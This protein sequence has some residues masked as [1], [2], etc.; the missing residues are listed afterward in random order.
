MDLPRSIR[1]SS[2]RLTTRFALS[3]FSICFALVVFEDAA[4]A[5]CLEPHPKVC[6]EFFRSDAVFVGTVLTEREVPPEGSSYDGWLY[7]IRIKQTFRGKL[8]SAVDV[9]TENSSGRYPL[10]VDETYLLF[11]QVFEGRLNIDNCGN[12]GPI[13]KTKDLI[14]QIHT[15]KRSTGGEIEGVVSVP[16]SVDDAS[17]IVIT[18]RGGQKTY[19]GITAKDGS[20]RIRVP[21]GEYKVEAKSSRRNIVPYDLSYDDPAHVIIHNGGCGQIKFLAN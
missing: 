18:V 7:H 10:A 15:I 16:D 8:Q 1:E 3:C 12:S 14:A 20:F 19:L 17:G 4:E 13:S 11:A 5:F 2:F 21:A 9:F 6:A